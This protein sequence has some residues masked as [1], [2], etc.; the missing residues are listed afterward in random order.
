MQL[1]DPPIPTTAGALTRD[2]IALLASQLQGAIVA[3]GDANYDEARSVHIETNA[4]P[5]LIVRAAEVSDV[6]ATITFAR[7]RQLDLAVRSGGHSIGGYSTLDGGLVLDLSQMKT[8]VVDPESR[9]ARLGAGLT[10]IE[11]AE[12]LH[13]LGLGL[14]AGDTAS[15]GVGGLSVGG[16]IGWFV[17]KYGLTIDRVRSIEVVTADGQVVT[18]SAS[19]HPDLFWAMRGGGGNFGVATSFEVEVHPA[20]MVYGGAVFYDAREAATVLPAYVSYAA[21]APDELTTMGLILMAPPA[22]FIPPD[23]VGKPVVGLAMIYSGDFEEGN[24]VV[25]PLRKL[26]TPVADIVGPMPYPAIFQFTMDAAVKNLRE[27]LG[28]VMVETV[29]EALIRALLDAGATNLPSHGAMVQ[30]RVLGGAMRRVDAGATA[31]AHRDKGGMVMAVAYGYD[32]AG[33]ERH[34]AWA[35]RCAEAMRLFGTGMYVGFVPPDGQDHTGEAYPPATLARLRTVKRQ[36][37]PTNFFH[38][39]LNVTPTE[40]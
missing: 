11:V 35:D 13:P 33:A 1:E 9:I 18:A 12:A 15:V 38:H 14:T 2:D 31:F 7:E 34:E 26:G 8:F 39:N 36:Y 5:A 27:R 6:A 3:P 21:S 30:F 19:E 16:G 29:D 10:W 4:R 17:R 40:E 20:G 24:R 37:D 32:D 28:S 22:P 25:D 23:M